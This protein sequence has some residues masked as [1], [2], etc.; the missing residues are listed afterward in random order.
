MKHKV[1][2]E[3]WEKEC[4]EGSCYES[5]TRLLVNGKQVLDSVTPVKAVK[6]VLDELG[7]VYELEEKHEYD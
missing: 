2:F 6:A 4:E 1:V 5:G 7:I 3:D